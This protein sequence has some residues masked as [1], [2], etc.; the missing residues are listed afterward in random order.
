[1]DSEVFENIPCVRMNQCTQRYSNHLNHDGLGISV[2]SVVK[3]KVNWLR[4]YPESVLIQ[5][6]KTAVCYK[7]NLQMIILLTDM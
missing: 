1:M 5:F 3:N 2:A 6:A 7:V 4:I